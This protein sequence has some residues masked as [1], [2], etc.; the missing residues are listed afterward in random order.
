[1]PPRRLRTL[2]AALLTLPFAA[3]PAAAASA[4]P[5]AAAQAPAACGQPGQWLRP[6]AADAPL[7]AGALLERLADR[8]VVLLGETH[9]SAEDHRWQLHTLVQLHSRRPQLALALEMFPRRLQPALDRWV[10]GELDEA[11][12]LRQSEWDKV[13]GFDARD[14]LP[15]FHFARMH[16][17]P[18]L[19]MNVERDLIDAVARSGWEGVPADRREGV[20]RPAEPSADYLK[21]LREVYRQHPEQTKE[22][23]PG[24]AGLR[25]FIE[26]QTVWDRAMAQTIAEHL[27]RNPEALVVGI[28]G[29]GHVRHGHGVAHQLRD[30][31][32]GRVAGLFTWK[33][34][35]ACTGLVAGLA[36]A[37][38]IVAPPPERPPRLGIAMAAEKGGVRIVSVTPG[39]LAERSGLKAGD[40]IVETGGLPLRDMQ[41][42][43]GVVY[44]QPPGTWLPMKLRR[45]G[46]ET[47]IVVR[48]PVAGG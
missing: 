23:T 35:D 19:A 15:L 20:S 16:R 13:W 12:F 41:G 1:M 21:T 39:S 22:K 30:L 33:H 7:A 10:A 42:L 14:Y 4:A 38:Q 27:G 25:R 48:F 24:E 45:D 47:E 5:T 18:M 8:Q 40:V 9:D 29:S 28:L 3:V 31:G 6:G 11:E 2:A 46:G 43:R 37:V 26:A 44:R 36:D 17:L 34:S 32:V